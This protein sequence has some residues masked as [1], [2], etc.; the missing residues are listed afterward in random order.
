MAVGDREFAS[1]G[2]YALRIAFDVERTKTRFPNTAKIEIWNLKLDT[3]RELQSKGALA[4]RL[5]V[6]YENAGLSQIFF[7][8]LRRIWNR[9][10]GGT[11]LV[12]ALF[13]GD[14]TT[15]LTA[16][17]IARTFPK[18]TPIGSVLETLVAALKLGTGNLRPVAAAK[19]Q[20]RVLP[21]ALSLS[22][23]VAEELQDFTRSF[24]L[25]WSIQDGAFTITEIGDPIPGTVGPLIS[26]TSGLVESPSIDPKTKH[27][28]GKCLMKPTLL[29]GATFKVESEFV[30][31]QYVAV[32]TKHSGDWAAQE[33]YTEFEGKPIGSAT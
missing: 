16:S 1:K 3:A 22:G 31:G 20:G 28:T 12:T 30:S 23:S 27:V 8:E 15:P 2:D 4:V 32:K 11:D 5:E 17:T 9:R 33:W 26:P 29:P 10:E 21:R 18:G 13:G 7:G 6:G 19:L 25:E 24:G 14:A